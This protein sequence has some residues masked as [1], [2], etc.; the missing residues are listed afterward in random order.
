M[1]LYEKVLKSIPALYYYKLINFVD[2][3]PSP[4]KIPSPL[5]PV[6]NSTLI[7]LRKIVTDVVS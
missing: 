6:D 4:Y 5:L 1:G 3:F 7:W 2:R